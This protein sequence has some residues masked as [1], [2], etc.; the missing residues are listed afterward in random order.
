[1]TTAERLNSVYRLSQRSWI[2]AWQ[3][4]EAFH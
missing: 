4:V 2:T 1:M 3:Y